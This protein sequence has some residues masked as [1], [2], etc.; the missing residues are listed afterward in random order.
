[1]KLN[2]NKLLKLINLIKADFALA[3][4]NLNIIIQ[5]NK[6]QK[7]HILWMTL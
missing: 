1:L 4:L 2:K 5:K 7:R 6:R 3:G